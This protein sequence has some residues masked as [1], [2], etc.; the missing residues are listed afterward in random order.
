MRL[1][2]WVCLLF[3][4]WVTTVTSPISQNDTLDESHN[5]DSMDYVSTYAGL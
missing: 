2:I 3:S 5:S 1:S 4:Y